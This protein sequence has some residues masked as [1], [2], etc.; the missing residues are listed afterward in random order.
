MYNFFL[1]NEACNINSVE[2][3]VEGISNLIVINRADNDDFYKSKRFYDSP[4]FDFFWE[5]ASGLECNAILKFIESLKS[6][7]DNF[8][9]QNI[10]VGFLGIDFT[11]CDI[12]ETKQIIDSESFK[13][14]KTLHLTTLLVRDKNELVNILNYLYPNYIFDN[15]A[16]DELIGWCEIDMSIY[17][18]IHLLLSEI[19]LNPFIGGH[20]KTEALKGTDGASKRI[21]HGDMLI[22]SLKGDK[23]YIHKCKDHYS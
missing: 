11:S 9:N 16:I 3:F 15:L 7:D 14:C 2:Y 21:T 17:S 8:L 4:I 20:G 23:I 19:K 1:L 10:I 12:E 13:D 6:E 5:R 18:K 22:Y